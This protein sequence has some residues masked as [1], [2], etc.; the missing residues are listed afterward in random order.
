MSCPVPCGKVQAPANAIVG[1]PTMN[2]SAPAA[3]HQWFGPALAKTMPPNASDAVRQGL[4]TTTE[5]KRQLFHYV[6]R[7]LASSAEKT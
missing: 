4:G 6:K 7:K 2:V 3:A 1:A 5:Q